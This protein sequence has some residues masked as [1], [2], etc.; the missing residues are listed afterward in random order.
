MAWQFKSVNNKNKIKNAGR[1]R[2]FTVRLMAPCNMKCV[3]CGEYIGQGKKFNARKED[4]ED[5]N[6]LGLRIYR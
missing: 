1:N 4:V 6:Y 2:T 3:T 5:M